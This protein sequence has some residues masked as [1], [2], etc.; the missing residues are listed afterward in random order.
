MAYSLTSAASPK[1]LLAEIV[2]F[3]TAQGWTIDYDHANGSGSTEGGQIALHSGNCF[4]AIGEP[5]SSRNPIAVTNSI[6]G[7]FNDGELGMALCSA[8]NS[9]IQY[10]GHT[11]SIVTTAT[12]SDRVLINDVYG[13]MDEVHFFGDENYILVAVKCS[14][15]RWTCFGFG[16]LDVQGMAAP[17]AGFAFANYS[18]WW[19]TSTTGISGWRHQNS[20]LNSFGS[21]GNNYLPSSSQGSGRKSLQ[22]F[23]PA[24]LLDT[25]FGFAAGPVVYPWGGNP[26][27]RSLAYT[28]GAESDGPTGN[29]GNTHPLDFIYFMNP[30]PTTGGLAL[31]AM[32]IFHLNDTLGLSSFLGELPG[33]R[34]CKLNNLSPGAQV[35]YGADEYLVFPWKQKGTIAE[36]ADP[37]YTG[38]PNT[39]NMGY[40]LQKA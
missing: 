12:D 34:I 26:G 17:A 23:I 39:G 37:L 28:S 31:H 35:N 21:G 32:P 5:S 14:G 16:N 10:W 13:P 30:Q 1:A 6:L 25:A 11:N 38:H 20:V 18:A 7:S 33:I 27:P 29:A 36:G 19:S 3:A 15:Q 2:T 8:F 4:V 9:N 40:A 22:I 24:G